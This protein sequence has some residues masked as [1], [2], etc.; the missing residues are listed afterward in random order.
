MLSVYVKQNGTWTETPDPAATSVLY[1]WYLSQW[2]PVKSVWLHRYSATLA[3]SLWEEVMVRIQEAPRNVRGTGTPTLSSGTLAWAPPPTATGPV[4]YQVLQR[5]EGSETVERRWPTDTTWTPSTTQA[6]TGLTTDTRYFFTVVA[7]QVATPQLVSPESA[8]A[9]T[10]LTGHAAVNRQGAR[11]I[12]ISPTGSGT[13]SSDSKW[14]EAE[15]NVIQGFATQGVRNGRGCVQYKTTY[16][17][18]IKL[19][20]SNHVDHADVTSA[21][22]VSVYR[23]ADG[24]SAPSVHVYACD[25]NFA[26]T[27]RPDAVGEQF[28]TFTAPSPTSFKKDFVITD[29]NQSG[30]GDDVD[31]LQNWAQAWI[32]QTK[33]HNGIMIFRADG[34]GNDDVG[35]NGYC[36]FKG[37][38]PDDW[39]L[40]LRLAWDYDNPTAKASAWNA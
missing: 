31:R 3:K 14:N 2:R 19:I 18:A 5:R 37:S 34:T 17:Q 22:V 13:W 6:I 24:G 20:D 39:H 32:N 16:A 35:H 7:R 9:V 21:R 33:T 10:L 15:N 28:A 40:E 23:R 26:S 29:K 25:V 38:G 11:T 4:E 36:T 1:A 30:G 8:P 12:D 27:A